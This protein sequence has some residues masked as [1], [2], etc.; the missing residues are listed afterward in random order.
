MPKEKKQPIR[1]LCGT[2]YSMTNCERCGWNADEAARRKLLPL[3]ER[4]DGLRR[5]I[6][7][8]KQVKEVPDND[9]GR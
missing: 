6:I 1:C 5:K 4:E 9:A 7:P 3:I 8:S 2:C